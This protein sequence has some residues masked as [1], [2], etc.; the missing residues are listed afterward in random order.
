M[1]KKGEKIK[2]TKRNEE[3][4]EGEGEGEGECK[5]R[6]KM[7]KIEKRWREESDQRMINMKGLISD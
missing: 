4:G 2:S 3:E 7:K 1:K 5:K 6:Q